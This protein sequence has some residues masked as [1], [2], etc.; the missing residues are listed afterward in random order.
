MSNLTVKHFDDYPK[1]E[2][3]LADVLRLMNNDDNVII[4]DE[5]F[6]EVLWPSGKVRDLICDNNGKVNKLCSYVVKSL[7]VS[8]TGIYVIGVGSA[9]NIITLR[10]FLG[11]LEIGEDNYIDILLVDLESDS[12]KQREVHA[13]ISATNLFLIK[14]RAWEGH[15]SR[16]LDKVIRSVRVR[17]V[18]KKGVM[19]TNNNGN[20]D[21][22]FIIDMNLL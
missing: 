20:F 9:T 1:K 18:D 7:E 3:I 22:D 19:S 10:Q 2:I 13:T 16:H 15:I 4:S 5:N 17:E 8:S 21:A 6:M 11:T 14:N 12:N